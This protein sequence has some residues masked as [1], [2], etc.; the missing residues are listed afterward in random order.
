M[1]NKQINKEDGMKRS[2]AM[3]W[4]VLATVGMLVTG[5]NKNTNGPEEETA[6]PGVTDEQTSMKTQAENDEFV[7]NDELT[8]ADQAIAATDY[9]YV[10][11]SIN[12]SVTPLRWGRF[13][14]SV[15]RQVT[16]TI[17]PGDTIAIARVHK[18]ITGTLKIKA[19]GTTGDTVLIEKPFS[20]QSDRNVVFRRIAN[21]T[22]YWRNWIPVAT[23]LVDGGTPN[24]QIDIKAITLISTRDTVT[25]TN[26][27]DFY[28]RYKWLRVLYGNK[29]LFNRD[30][31]VAEFRG[32]DSV[33]VRVTLESASADTDLV[34][35][36][37]GFNSLY[38]N[39]A[40]MALVRQETGG[41]LGYVKVFE[42]TFFVHP[43][44]GHF[45]AG[46]D[47]MT[48]AT[49]FDDSPS[50]YSVSWWGVPYRV[51]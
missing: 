28:M 17:Q 36:R 21:S 1:S 42:R 23:S 41:T 4:T 49:L 2:L 11:G 47:A 13:I 5:C 38:K 20:D 35:L 44:P 10:V 15:T 24:G 33:K 50:A 39:R 43:R 40:R 31:D 14:S 25:I 6:P 26:P 45:H 29:D 46:I 12:A 32:G 3:M 7:K 48:R 34:A 8:F 19:I 30:R 9:A 27:L 22:R 37:F 51:F 16:T 18:T